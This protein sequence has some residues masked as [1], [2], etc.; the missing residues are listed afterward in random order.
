LLTFWNL[1]RVWN[2][3][4][5]EDHDWMKVLARHKK[6]IDRSWLVQMLDSFLPRSLMIFANLTSCWCTNQRNSEFI[7]MIIMNF[8][9]IFVF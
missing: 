2:M 5:S 9:F 7:I 8:V 1:R 3:K 6:F 4:W